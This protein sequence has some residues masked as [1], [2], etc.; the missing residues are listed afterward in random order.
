MGRFTDDVEVRALLYCTQE[1]NIAFTEQARITDCPYRR[2]SRLA[3]A[4]R[5]GWY[6]ARTYQRLKHIF[7][8]YETAYP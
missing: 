3:E 8:K 2:G 5:T 7:D 6:D 4:W 1:G